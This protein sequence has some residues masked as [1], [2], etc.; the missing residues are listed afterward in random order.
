MGKAKEP[1]QMNLPFARPYSDMALKE[2][3][4]GVKAVTRELVRFGLDEKA[5]T[6]IMEIIAIWEPRA[7]DAIDL[8]D[9]KILA[10]QD[11]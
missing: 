10:A 11:D 8:M 3:A 9:Q 7:L 1:I 6:G 5:I 4:R 2:T